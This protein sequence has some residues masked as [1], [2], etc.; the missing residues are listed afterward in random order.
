MYE[1]HGWIVLNETPYETD[2]GSFDIKVKALSERI[3]ALDWSSAAANLSN[4]NGM[5]VVTVNGCPNRRRYKAEELRQLLDLIVGEFA[6]AYGIIYE[7]DDEA[8]T[9]PLHGERAFSVTVIKR[10]KCVPAMDPFLSP[11]VPVIEDPFE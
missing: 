10:G 7:E 11:M 8:T 3:A 6:G 4:L 9:M 1:F 5:F 2:V